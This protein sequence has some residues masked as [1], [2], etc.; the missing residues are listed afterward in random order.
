[1]LMNMDMEMGNLKSEM[2]M[3]MGNT[4]EYGNGHGNGHENGKCK[5]YVNGDGNGHGN[6]NQ[7]G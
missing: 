7:N 2:V 3:D 4:L 5:G 1:M 6:G